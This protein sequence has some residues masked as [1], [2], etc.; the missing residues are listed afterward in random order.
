VSIWDSAVWDTDL[1]DFAVDGKSFTGGSLGLG[2]S[3][4]IAMNGNAT[5][6]I[7]IV[8]WDVMFKSG[9]FL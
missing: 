3:F 8:G 2:R 9:G 5:T 7:N 1:W 4:A 6:R